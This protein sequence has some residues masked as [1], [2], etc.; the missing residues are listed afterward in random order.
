MTGEYRGADQQINP[1]DLVQKVI[2]VIQ[3]H[4]QDPELLLAISQ[5][6]LGLAGSDRVKS[7][8][9]PI[10]QGSVVTPAPVAQGILEM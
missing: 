8:S 1:A 2:E 5:D 7:P 9:P 4:I 10:V 3:V 6:L